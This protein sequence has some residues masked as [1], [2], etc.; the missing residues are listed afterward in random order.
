MIPKIVEPKSP[1]GV[2]TGNYMTIRN[3][4]YSLTHAR[5]V[6]STVGHKTVEVNVYDSLCNNL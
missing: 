4:L 5:C 6:V 2:C 3:D 1:G